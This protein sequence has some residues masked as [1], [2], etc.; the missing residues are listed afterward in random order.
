MNT[1]EHARLK[2]HLKMSITRLRSLQQKKTAVAKANRRELAGLLN[3]GKDASA[4][5]RVENII[6]GDIN[7]KNSILY[8]GWN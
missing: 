2:A 8:D 4:R 7:G 1:K 6:R 3:Q 5:I